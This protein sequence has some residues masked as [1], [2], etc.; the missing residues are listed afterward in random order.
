[1]QI[2][3]KE[4]KD[5]AETIEISSIINVLIFFKVLKYSWSWNT[6]VRNPLED[7]WILNAEC[8]VSL[9]MFAAATPVGASSR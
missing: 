5:E 9:W 6:K 8:S 3:L 1:M 7:S 2:R 4:N